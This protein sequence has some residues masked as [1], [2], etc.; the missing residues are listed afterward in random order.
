ML[1]ERPMM[2]LNYC[3]NDQGGHQDSSEG[4][5]QKPASSKPEGSSRSSLKRVDCVQALISSGTGPDERVLLVWN[6]DWRTPCWSLPGGGREK[7]ETLRDALLREVREETG[8][9]VEVDGLIDVHE[10]IGLGGRIHLVIFT[11]RGHPIGGCLTT[12]GSCE[13]ASGG[14]SAA[15]WFSLEEARE[16]KSLTRILDVATST[17]PGYSFERRL[18]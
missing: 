17:P 13:P 3:V 2:F 9:E 4:E 18:S 7:N 1:C 15:R 12:D 8:L 11:F 16:F 6:S 10:I 5:T 14:V